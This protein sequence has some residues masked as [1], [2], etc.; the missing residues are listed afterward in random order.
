M[1]TVN[2]W[3]SGLSRNPSDRASHS[4]DGVIRKKLA[5]WIYLQ[6]CPWYSL[7]L[8]RR[9]HGDSISSSWST[10]NMWDPTPTILLISFIHWPYFMQIP[11][12]VYSHWRREGIIPKKLISLLIYRSK[13]GSLPQTPSTWCLWDESC[14]N[15]PET[16]VKSWIPIG[17]RWWHRP[18]KG[19]RLYRIWIRLYKDLALFLYN[20]GGGSFDLF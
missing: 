9:T 17:F 1:N 13:L 18:S 16:P 8:L 7:P 15:Y 20:Y 4:S 6:W 10:W 5:S 19:R 2:L 12:M 14:R 11:T 3:Q